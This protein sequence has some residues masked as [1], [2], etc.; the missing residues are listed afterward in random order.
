M[1]NTA[2]SERLLA[3]D[4]WRAFAILAVLVGHFFPIPGF[5]LGLFGVELFFVLSGRLMADI[6]FVK[7]LPLGEF[8]Y[9]RATRILPA[10]IVFVV[11]F[12]VFGL[13]VGGYFEISPLWVLASVTFVQNYML[14]FVK[15]SGW[16]DH[17][18]SLCVE[19]HSYLLL[20][21]LA[22]LIG[23]GPWRPVV[24]MVVVAIAAMIDG[25]FSE[26]VLHQ[27]FFEDYGRS[28]VHLSSIFISGAVYLLIRHRMDQAVVQRF[29]PWIFGP[30]I[31]AAV[32]LNFPAFPMWVQYTLGTS[33]LAVG[34]A[35]C[36][37]SAKPVVRLLS[38]PWLTRIGIWSYSLYLWQE[39]FY[40]M[41]REHGG[42]VWLMLPCAVAAGLA[43]YYLVERPARR[44]LNAMWGRWQTRKAAVA[45]PAV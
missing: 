7:K 28:D 13:I 30:A 35:L 15:P 9:R 43:S 39:P 37:V 3:L 11:A 1:P 25:A 45:Q 32:L 26:I 36:E 41:V 44:A 42:N 29:A 18:W 20:G 40:K 22:F 8:F 27:S 38:L 23:R 33:L 19:E 16:F 10:L 14:A 34:V 31:A 24:A 21:L 4:G 5:N 17:M 6:L 2:G 12:F